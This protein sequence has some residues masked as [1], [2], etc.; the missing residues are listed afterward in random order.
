MRKRHPDML[1]QA[2]Q[3]VDDRL[4][5]LHDRVGVGRPTRIVRHISMVDEGGIGQPG[6]SPKRIDQPRGPQ[7][8]RTSLHAAEM[9][10]QRRR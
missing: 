7:L 2:P 4:A 10:A 1:G 9:T 3:V 6:P 8:G 5:V